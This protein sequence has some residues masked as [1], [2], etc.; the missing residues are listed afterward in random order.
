MKKKGLIKT[1]QVSVCFSL[2]QNNHALFENYWESKQ[3]W[4]LPYVHRISSPS[5][6]KSR[7]VYQTIY[8]RSSQKTWLWQNSAVSLVTYSIHC[9]VSNGKVCRKLHVWSRSWFI[10]CWC[11]ANDQ[12]ERRMLVIR[13][14]V[15]YVTQA[16]PLGSRQMQS[17]DWETLTMNLQEMDHMP[18]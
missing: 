9:S 15:G 13:N 17:A 7:L 4:S 5:A 12:V 8:Q 16:N 2:W 18:F 3:V 10:Y 14:D 11:E 6:T 1:V